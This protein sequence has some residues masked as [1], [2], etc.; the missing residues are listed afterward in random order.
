VTA[1]AFSRSRLLVALLS[2]TGFAAC[3]EASGAPNAEPKGTAKAAVTTACGS[4]GQPD[5]PLQGWMKATVQQYLNAGDNER[6]A[7]SLGEL[8]KHAPQGY[9]GWEAAAKAGADAAQAGD[10]AGVRK[11]CQS[12]HQKHRPR[13][14]T[15]M[16][17]VK[18]F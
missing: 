11:Q 6:L 9:E 18:L 5:C 13:F 14:R 17:N 1:A 3:S 10:I 16:R 15:E 8:A 4:K 12:C 2:I 7:S